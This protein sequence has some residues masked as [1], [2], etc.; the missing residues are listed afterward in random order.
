[1]PDKTKLKPQLNLKVVT[2]ILASILVASTLTA[3]AS[4][5]SKIESKIAGQNLESFL[6]TAR[7]QEHQALVKR[8]QQMKKLALL[9]QKT[10][11][12]KSKLYADAH[13]NLVFPSRLKRYVKHLT[14]N[15]NLKQLEPNQLV[16]KVLKNTSKQGHQSKSMS[17]KDIKKKFGLKKTHIGKKY[18]SKAEKRDKKVKS[19]RKNYLLNKYGGKALGKP[20]NPAH[21]LS[22]KILAQA[23]SQNMG[24]SSEGIPMFDMVKLHTE[25]SNLSN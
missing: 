22:H 20:M 18:E 12:D 2:M 23:F 7:Q 21:H 25:E 15:E 11:E 13:G 5:T 16:E 9:A 3:P 10:K 6:E 24:T 1:M 4:R 17:E 14:G 8:V 19:F